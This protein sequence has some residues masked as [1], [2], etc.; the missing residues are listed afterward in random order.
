[1]IEKMNLFKMIKILKMKYN[2]IILKLQN[3]NLM[4]KLED[5]KVFKSIIIKDNQ[6]NRFLIS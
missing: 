4:I 1:M 5:F 3:L 6:K 2:L